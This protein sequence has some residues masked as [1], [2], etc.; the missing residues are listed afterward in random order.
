MP[1]DPPIRA[2][3]FD[4]YGTLARAVSWGDTHEQVFDRHGLR[5]DAST[6][7]HNFVGEANDGDAHLEHSTTRDAYV[8]WELERMRR[9]ARA[10]GVGEDD[11]EALVGDLHRAAKTYTLAPYDEVPDVLAELRT[12]GMVLAICSNWDWD[13]D[14]AVAQAGLEDAVDVVVTSARAGARKPH[15]RIFRH[16][17]ERCMVAP[18]EAL[19]VG[20]TFSADVAGPV[21]YGMHA[22]H[23]WRDDMQGEAPLLPEG[24]TR[25]RDITAVLD[26]V[27]PPAPM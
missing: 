21:A 26:L 11:L 6:W 7:G 13:I 14:R 1:A 18:P 9:R 3:L 2:V 23:V 12:R 22:L 19:F 8:A 20:D 27:G 17:L 24:A 5:F 10:C 25:A 16:T 15:A 4:F